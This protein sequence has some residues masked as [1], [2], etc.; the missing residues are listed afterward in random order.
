MST[1]TG[2]IAFGLSIAVGLVLITSGVA[3]VTNLPAFLDAV[4][5]YELVGRRSARL[6][7]STLPIVELAL[8]V[9]WLTG[10]WVPLVAAVTSV[11]LVTLTLAMLVNI[12]RGRK[13][14]CGCGG[15]L[16][17]QLIGTATVVRTL[18]LLGVVGLAAVFGSALSTRL[19]TT[20]PLA[21]LALTVATAL[22][23]LVAIALI[24]VLLTYRATYSKAD[25][26]RP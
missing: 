21:E 8:G 25:W 23:V 10:I 22:S 9:A 16:G 2:S 13:V 14:A 19:L 26:F 18:A 1:L 6:L 5:Q 11:L 7:S 20:I 4:E 12:R 17:S 15:I 3:K 24:E